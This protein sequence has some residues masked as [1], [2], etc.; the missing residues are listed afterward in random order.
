MDYSQLDEL[1]ARINASIEVKKKEF[2]QIADDLQVLQQQAKVLDEAR[3]LLIK[4]KS[5][6]ESYVGRSA[7]DAF[8]LQEE[9]L[10]FLVDAKVGV[11]ISAIASGLKERGYPRSDS[12]NFYT[13]VFVTVKRLVDRGKVEEYLEVEGSKQRL[14][15][16]VSGESL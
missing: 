5:V 7:S 14:Y 1:L 9:V 8:G 11:A 12:K 4:A 6:E 15:R 16:A 3:M 2:K 13:S 10:R